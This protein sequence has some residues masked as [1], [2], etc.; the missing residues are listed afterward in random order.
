MKRKDQ[1][2]GECPL[3]ESARGKRVASGPSKIGVNEKAARY[4]HPPVFCQKSPQTIEN[5]REQAEKERQESSRA[6]KLLKCGHLVDRGPSARVAR[7]GWASFAG[8]E[9]WQGKELARL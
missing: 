6:R 5:K 9:V 3:S 2:S 1:E 8:T 7:S 4:P